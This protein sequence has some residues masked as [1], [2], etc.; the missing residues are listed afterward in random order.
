MRVDPSLSQLLTKLRATAIWP[1]RPEGTALDLTVETLLPHRRPFLLVDAIRQVDIEG[2]R[3]RACHY[4]SPDDPVFAGHFPDQPIYPGVLTIEAIGQ[5]AGCLAA[6]V[7]RDGS[8][9]KDRMLGLRASRLHHVVFLNPIGP[10]DEIDLQV[11]MLEHDTIMSTFAG[12]AWVRD[13]LCCLAIGEC[14]HAS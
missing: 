6:L 1:T 2:A 5:A 4:I 9:E 10:G 8:G 3:L 14:V 7:A 13:T 12:Q 11:S